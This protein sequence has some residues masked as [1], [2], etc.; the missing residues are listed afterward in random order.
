MADDLHG[1]GT[2]HV[3]PGVAARTRPATLEAR[4]VGTM[5][6][7]DIVASV[8]VTA[9]ILAIMSLVAGRAVNGD[10]GTDLG[11][12]ALAVGLGW[13]VGTLGIHAWRL[14]LIRRNTLQHSLAAAL[15]TLGV[16]FVVFLI[17]LAVRLA[18]GLDAPG[19]FDGTVAERIG[20]AAAI[21]GILT[22]AVVSSSLLAV[23]ATNDVD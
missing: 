6:V 12:F 5:V 20:P 18:S 7:L 1:G 11:L 8:L 23:G 2:R 4:E 3:E 17:D 10:A 21:L 9:G 19:I 14:N 16:V 15:A 22:A 13:F